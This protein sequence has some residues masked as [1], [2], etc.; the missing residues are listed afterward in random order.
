MRILALLLLFLSISSQLVAQTINGKVV[1]KGTGLGIP[2]ANLAWK[3]GAASTDSLGGFLIDLKG[4]KTININAVDYQEFTFTY[5]STSLTRL[6][7][8]LESNAKGVGQVTI[9]HS[10][11]KEKLR[12]SPVTVES[13]QRNPCQRFLR[14][15]GAFARRGCYGRQSWLSHCKHPWFQQHQPGAKLAAD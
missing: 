1:D 8:E 15:V 13:H 6:V 2:Y 12:E 4:A 10:R 7:I 11:L 5:N 9:S 14:R 3:G